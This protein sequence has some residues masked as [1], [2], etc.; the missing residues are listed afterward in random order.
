[1]AK[2]E[3]LNLIRKEV[4]Q[5]K[6]RETIVSDLIFAG[7]K[8]HDIEAGFADL[9]HKGEVSK[10]F[11]SEAAARSLRPPLHEEARRVADVVGTIEPSRT[12]FEI[13]A[14]LFALYRHRMVVWG[15]G[16]IAVII[17]GAIGYFAYGTISSV[18]VGRSLDIGAGASS[19]SYRLT[20][21]GP[22][23][24]NYQDADV[25]KRI[26]FSVDQAIFVVDGS[27]ARVSPNAS[28]LSY[29]IDAR[30][31]GESDSRWQENIILSGDGGSFAQVSDVVASSTS[32]R[33]AIGRI[34]RRWIDIG[35]VDDLVRVPFAGPRGLW[36]DI[37]LCRSALGGRNGNLFSFLKQPGVITGIRRVGVEQKD[38]VPAYHFVLTLSGAAASQADPSVA[39]CVGAQGFTHWGAVLNG[40]WDF[41]VNKKT[42]EP[43]SLNRSDIVQSGA[44]VTV[45]LS[46]LSM[47]F[48]HWNQPLSIG[49][50]QSFLSAQQA[51]NIVTDTGPARATSTS[52]AP[53][54]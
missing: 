12:K 3:L 4:A 31:L 5:K 52:G 11:L 15:G 35:S 53:K 19:Y 44:G 24:I 23:V 51:E 43:L 1:M 49:S 38:G 45:G 29:A 22:V 47:D 16:V 46:T 40:S 8:Y 6:S 26:V 30:G 37:F 50:P 25:F 9:F 48:D 39:A 34:A 36:N 54:K 20:A 21:Q 42:R 14:E 17:V 2:D 10:E 18:I 27:F 28:A 41:F 33:D 32:W 13:A 7:W